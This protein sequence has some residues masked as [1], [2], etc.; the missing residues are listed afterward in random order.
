MQWLRNLLGIKTPAEVR[1]AGRDYVDKSY[2]NFGEAKIRMKEL[3]HL[4]DPAIDYGDFDRGMRDRLLE[5]KIPHPL[6]TPE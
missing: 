5:L 4:C 1:Q 6:D 3:W 2:A